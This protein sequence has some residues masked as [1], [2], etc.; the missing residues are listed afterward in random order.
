MELF[1][2]VPIYLH[3]VHRDYFT[4]Y[5]QTTDF[6]VVQWLIVVPFDAV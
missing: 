5:M 6:H 1:L 4:I 2:H 3:D